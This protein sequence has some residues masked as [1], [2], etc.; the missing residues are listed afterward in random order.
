MSPILTLRDAVL[1]D[2]ETIFTIRTSVKENHL[3]REE[4]AE[5][6]ITPQTIADIIAESPCIWLVEVDDEPAGFA[7]A[8]AEEACLF[9]M[10]VLPQFEGLGLGKLLLKKAEAF[11][12][13]QQPTIWLETA[14]NS[15]AAS[16]YQRNGWLPVGEQDSEDIRFEKSR[17]TVA[18]P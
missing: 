18:K 3:S 14:A 4:M 7:M 13:A 1:A 12:F 17:P 8:I 2:I 15:R 16:F 6:G 10:F 5:M 11:L 9:A